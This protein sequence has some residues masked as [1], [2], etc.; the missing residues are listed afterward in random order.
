M[1][2]FNPYQPMDYGSPYGYPSGGPQSAAGGPQA[3]MEIGRASC[4][5]RV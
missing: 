2:Y 1:A 5:E 3:F 4:R